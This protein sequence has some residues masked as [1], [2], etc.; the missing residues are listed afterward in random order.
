MGKAERGDNRPI[1]SLG[2]TVAFCLLGD[3]M[4]YAVLPTK[5]DELFL[6]A[7]QV[8]WLLSVNRFVR[9]LTNPLAASLFSRFKL[10][11]LIAAAVLLSAWSTASYAFTFSFAGLLVARGCWGV[12]W[13][14]LR[15]G[16]YLAIL[17]PKGP[18]Q[19][20][21]SIGVFIRVYRSGMLAGLLLGGP[22]AD[23]LGYGNTVFFL[24]ACTLLGFFTIRCWPSLEPSRKT[25]QSPSALTAL[26]H[27]KH[28][29]L[30]A[31]AMGTSLIA[32]GL[33][34]ATTGH[35]L[36]ERFGSF[37]MDLG[38]L[39]LSV[40]TL[41]AALLSSR[42]AYSLLLAPSL[43]RLADR[44]GARL[45]GQLGLCLLLAGSG[46]LLLRPGLSWSILSHL[47]V[48]LGG[49]ILSI[50]LPLELGRAVNDNVRSHALAAQATWS[51]LGAAVGPILGY[52]LADRFGL[53]WGYAF[54]L[55]ISAALLL[56]RSRWGAKT[57]ARRDP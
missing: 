4:L 45:C 39:L 43:G 14:L 6:S 49:T 28:L 17:S 41:T 53:S 30:S 24:A 56:F 52:G 26:I 16:G 11:P 8:G 10:K 7:V 37:T 20:G 38:P 46:A 25:S 34:G 27:P 9:I 44:L 35:Y 3:S 48:F 31:T 21:R 29:P 1:V 54:A 5:M 47:L 36:K 50:T 33:V 18:L 32:A 40:T 19:Q 42:H 55:A 23:L 51:D 2:A 57:D 13:S 15:L 22:L 12:C